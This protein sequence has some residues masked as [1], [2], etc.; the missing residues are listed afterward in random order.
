MGEFDFAF[1]YFDGEV[2]EDD[3]DYERMYGVSFS[4][5]LASGVT[6]YSEVA[7]F[8]HNYRN[9]YDNEGTDALDDE[10]YVQGVVGSY[11]IFSGESFLSFFNGSAGMTLEAYYNGSGYSES[12]RQN[13]YNTLDQALQSGDPSVLGDYRF[14]GM[15][16]FY[17]LFSYNNSF[18]DRYTAELTG[19]FAQDLSCSLQA[20]LTYNL[21]DY[22][23][24]SGKVTH[25]QGD[26][27]SE[28]GN[29]AVSDLFELMLDI[30]F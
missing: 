10:L 13:Y 19:L 28:F 3:R 2:H 5:N 8:E 23:S 7:G 4:T 27:E 22:Y 17:A 12:E 20:Q 16:Q 1:Y 25:N 30:N 21:S 29:A 6:L 26:D 18:K 11:I 24:L 14:S 9:Y 15:N